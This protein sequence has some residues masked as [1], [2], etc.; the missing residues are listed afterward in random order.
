MRILDLA[1]DPGKDVFAKMVILAEQTGVVISD[2]NVK[3]CYGLLRADNAPKTIIVKF[4]R[5][6][7]T[8]NESMKKR[9]KKNTT[10]K[11]FLLLT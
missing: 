6:E 9:I 4:V 10:L 11:F 1:E 3:T 8:Q 7:I 2:A 5:R